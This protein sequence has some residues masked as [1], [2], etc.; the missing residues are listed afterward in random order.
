MVLAFPYR[1]VRLS[2]V[3]TT[4]T[5]LVIVNLRLFQPQYSINAQF[6]VDPD[7]RVRYWFGGVPGSTHDK[8][9]VHALEVAFFAA[10][11]RR[12][13]SYRSCAAWHSRLLFQIMV[14]GYERITFAIV[15]DEVRYPDRIVGI[16]LLLSSMQ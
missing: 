9:K 12:G 3:A 2:V 10:P 4:S 8:Y 15:P 14:Q 16:A 6:V 1:I 11:S 13:L 5:G 7:A